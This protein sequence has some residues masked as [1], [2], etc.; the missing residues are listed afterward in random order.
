MAQNEELPA[1]ST[2]NRADFF[3]P[4]GVC[5]KYQLTVGQA[6]EYQP[7]YAVPESK[8]HIGAHP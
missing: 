2:R 8:M 3:I 6:D 1:L 7:P 5:N 4:T